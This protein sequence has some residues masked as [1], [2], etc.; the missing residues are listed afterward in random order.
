M[1]VGI[2][3]QHQRANEL[4]ARLQHKSCDYFN[5]YRAQTEE[6]ADAY[7]KNYFPEKYEDAPGENGF[8][9]GTGASVFKVDGI[10][11]PGHGHS[12]PG[13]GAFTTKLLYDY[14]AFTGDRELM[15]TLA[16]S[17]NRG[18]AKFLHKQ[19]VIVPPQ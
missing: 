3:A 16:Y 6:Y 19:L 10:D 14:C 5:A 2:L 4:L 8:T 13:T 17:A 15:R 1:D 18:M 11:P 9:I 12:G 7:I